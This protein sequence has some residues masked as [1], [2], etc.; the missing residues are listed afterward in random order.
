M[1]CID[2][3]LTLLLLCANCRY[4]RMLLVLLQTYLISHRQAMSI[5]SSIGKCTSAPTVGNVLDR[6]MP[7]YGDDFSTNF[8]FSCANSLC[9]HFFSLLVLQGCWCII[10]FFV[11]QSK[12]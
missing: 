7:V 12:Y 2:S 8:K 5:C 6:V 1:E 9:Q 11:L 4:G 3:D 10:F